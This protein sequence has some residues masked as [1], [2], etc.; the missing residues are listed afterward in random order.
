M[1]HD[2]AG[3]I[4]I[5]SYEDDHHSDAVSARLNE[6]DRDVVVLSCEDYCRK[7]TASWTVVGDQP[8]LIFET[9]TQTFNASEISAWWF[10]R[11]PVF[12]PNDGLSGVDRYIES[13]KSIFLHMMLH[14]LADQRP[15]IDAPSQVTR[16][17]SKLLQQRVAVSRGLSVPATFTGGSPNL[18]WLWTHEVS[19]QLCSKAIEAGRITNEDGSAHAKFTTLFERRSEKELSSLR[20][21]PVNIQQFIPKQLE[22]RVTVIGQD[23]FAASIDVS[24][25]NEPSK[26]DWR[27][28]DWANTRYAKFE[29]PAPVRSKILAVMEDL[30]LHYGAF[31]F[32]VT[33]DEEYVFLEV[34][35]TGQFLWV[36]DL[37]DLPLTDAMAKLLIEKC[38]P[39]P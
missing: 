39:S 37:T 34:N 26:I 22:L 3:T 28:Y 38:T 33:P 36:E 9:D 20:S 31:D 32:V 12:P 35:P 13:Q 27:H 6:L 16:A 10:R 23:V 11:E 8:G 24:A 5:F 14:E 30:N 17:K 19:G 21:C 29:L 2:G 25:A 4:G 7:W 18:A 1:R 15:C